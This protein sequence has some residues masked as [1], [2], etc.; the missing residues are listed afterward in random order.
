MGLG[1]SSSYRKYRKPVRVRLRATAADFVNVAVYDVILGLAKGRHGQN[2][3][4]GR[5]INKAALTAINSIFVPGFRSRNVTL[6][7]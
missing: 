5:T 2:T 1:K 4:I 6:L 7:F 3:E